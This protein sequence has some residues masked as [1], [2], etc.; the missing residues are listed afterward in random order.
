M[1][2]VSNDKVKNVSNVKTTFFNLDN[3]GRNCPS[4][5][6]FYKMHTIMHM[7]AFEYQIR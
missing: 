4:L 2:L 5:I 3:I 7:Y 6:P 1:D